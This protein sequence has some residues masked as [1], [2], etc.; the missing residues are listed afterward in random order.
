MKLLQLIAVLAVCFLSLQSFAQQNKA[1]STPVRATTDISSPT[2]SPK[3]D[4]ELITLRA[5]NKIIKEYQSSLLDTVYWAL[6]AVF[7][8]AVILAGFGWF[9]NFKVYEAD[10]LR[11]KEDF[12]A[13][14]KEL[15]ANLEAKLSSNHVELLKTVEGKLDAL[16]ERLSRDMS[17]LRDELNS[18]KTKYDTRFETSEK[19]IARIETSYLN[20]SKKLALSNTALR[21]VEEYVWDL[22][23][24]P[25]N[26]L[27]TQCQGLDSAFEAGDAFYVK[28]ILDRMKTTME[29]KILA[30][31]RTIDDVVLKRI[32]G[33]LTKAAP[34]DGVGANDV[35]E[36]LKKIPLEK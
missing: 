13:R 27:I 23:G 21:E 35:R 22:R 6:A 31:G 32:D 3:E 20:I 25:I 12:N 30:T 17:A 2:L 1:G 8:V 14:S 28:H 16:V 19:E 36:V 5:Q 9:T 15:E 7:A 4:P 33:V 24:I 29:S 34:F 11:L 18:A 26:I 10:K